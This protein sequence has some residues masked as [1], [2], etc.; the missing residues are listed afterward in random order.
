LYS[1]AQT[2][3]ITRDEMTDQ[4]ITG[5]ARYSSIFN[6]PTPTWADMGAI[7]WLVDGAAIVNQ[8]PLCRC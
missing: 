6:Y 3:G 5:R 8:E 4:L 2:L 1:A 7:G